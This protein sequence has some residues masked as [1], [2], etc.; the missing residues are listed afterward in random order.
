MSET[1]PTPIPRDIANR[2]DARFGDDWHFDVRLH[3]VAGGDLVVEGEFK[4]N[5]R[6]ISHCVAVADDPALAA[7]S[8]GDKIETASARSLE[9]CVAGYDAG[10]AAF[11]HTLR[12]LC[13]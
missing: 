4:A 10:P 2:L 12:P 7:L 3:N 11:V 1:G 8:F 6:K 9:A 13:G 5:G